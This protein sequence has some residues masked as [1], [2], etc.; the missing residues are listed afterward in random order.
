MRVI[1]GKARGTRLAAPKGSS[2]RPT[3]DRV[4]ESLF[5]ILSGHLEGARFL[6]LFAGTGANGIEALSRGAQSACFVASN[7]QALNTVRRNLEISHLASD[8]VCLRLH[9]PSGLPRLDGSY[10]LIFADPPYNFSNYTSLLE[11]FCEH[12]L[13]SPG[14][15]IIIEHQKGATLPTQCGPLERHRESRYGGTQLSFYA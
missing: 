12:N 6:D 15:Q 5:N 7:A 9:L 8:A 1:A 14:A 2:I 10:D 11:G 4:R 3:L 13:A